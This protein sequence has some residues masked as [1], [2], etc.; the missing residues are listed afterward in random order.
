MDRGEINFA[1]LLIDDE[2]KII[3]ALNAKGTTLLQNYFLKDLEQSKQKD[4]L[5]VLRF[6]VE[7]DSTLFTLKNMK[8]IDCFSE[9]FVSE[10][11]DTSK[12]DDLLSFFVENLHIHSNQ[13]PSQSLD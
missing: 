9:E 12:N 3:R 8:K 1:K 5:L 4:Q 11:F 13:L 7:M 10:L 2:P 6:L